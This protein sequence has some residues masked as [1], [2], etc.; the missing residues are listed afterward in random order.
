MELIVF[1]LVVLGL[2]LIAVCFMLHTTQGYLQCQID[3]LKK[4][5]HELRIRMI[6]VEG[7][8]N[9]HDIEI[10][11]V[12]FRTGMNKINVDSMIKIFNRTF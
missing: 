5:N 9:I 8:T 7:K 11:G 12:E 4:Y 6:E 10:S 2:V 3:I 1:G